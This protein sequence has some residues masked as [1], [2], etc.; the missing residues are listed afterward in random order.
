MFDELSA[1]NR[2]IVALL[3]NMSSQEECSSGSGEDDRD[4]VKEGAGRVVDALI[5]SFEEDQL[6][7]PLAPDYPTLEKNSYVGVE[8][9]GTMGSI[10]CQKGT[11]S[12]NCREET[13][14]DEIPNLSSNH[15]TDQ[16]SSIETNYN[17]KVE[18]APNQLEDFRTDVLDALPYINSSD[19]TRA[20]IEV[21]LGTEGK[22]EI[23]SSTLIIEGWGQGQ[24][25]KDTSQATESLTE[26]GYD[27]GITCIS[28]LVCGIQPQQYD[29]SVPADTNHI[30]SVIN[31]LG[32]EVECHFK[33]NGSS[34]EAE[35]Q[36]SDAWRPVAASAAEAKRDCLLP[37]CAAE[38]ELV[39]GDLPDQ[40]QEPSR[41]LGGSGLGE[42]EEGGAQSKV[43]GGELKEWLMEKEKEFNEILGE[44]EDNDHQIESDEQTPMDFNMKSCEMK[45]LTCKTNQPSSLKNDASAESLTETTTDLMDELELQTE[46]LRQITE[47]TTAVSA[48]NDFDE[49]FRENN[50]Q[51]KDIC[52]KRVKSS[53]TKSK[54]IKVKKKIPKSPLLKRSEIQACIDLHN[55]CENADILQEIIQPAISFGHNPEAVPALEQDM[56]E[57]VPSREEVDEPVFKEEITWE[58]PP[59]P[60]HARK[61]VSAGSPRWQ[62]IRVVLLLQ[63]SFTLFRLPRKCQSG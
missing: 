26:E 4:K 31:E 5:L 44:G 21:A 12:K 28:P 41:H 38:T 10:E 16:A 54:P 55:A 58:D 7:D 39:G 52:M 18:S 62:P 43:Q 23:V 49:T 61:P 19:E 51:Q 14:E 50:S 29:T 56:L 53:S 25:F 13:G 20:L 24:D 35:S 30:D 2:E 33:P 3:E 59:Q 37:A 22:P 9:E 36:L 47:K 11:E 6:E 34:T 27:V 60:R 17:E 15:M 1:V 42:M 63:T 57:A 40:G 8:K 46:I 48:E 32:S 45:D